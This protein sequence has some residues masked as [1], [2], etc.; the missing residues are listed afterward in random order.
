MTSKILQ[1]LLWQIG[2]KSIDADK[3]TAIFSCRGGVLLNKL[4]LIIPPTVD[5]ILTAKTQ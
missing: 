1:C 2:G 4:T 3:L 5:D